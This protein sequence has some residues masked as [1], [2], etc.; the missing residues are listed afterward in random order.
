[1]AK[2]AATVQ[3]SQKPQLRAQID[4][5]KNLSSELN[6]VVAN[7]LPS[8]DTKDGYEL[9]KRL[10]ASARGPFASWVKGRKELRAK[11]QDERSKA[12][13]ERLA[14]RKTN[15]IARRKKLDE[16]LAKMA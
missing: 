14:K 2:Q 4:R 3:K 12:K 1:M 5:I 15:L 10:I 9:R 16:Q 11:G 6:A 7:V 8:L 13:T